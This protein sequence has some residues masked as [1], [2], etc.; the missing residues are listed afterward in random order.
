MSIVITIR[1]ALPMTTSILISKMPKGGSGSALDIRNS[2]P[3]TPLW[4]L[5]SST[6]SH[7]YRKAYKCVTSPSKPYP[8]L[9][10]NI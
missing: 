1:D 4:N 3:Y 9:E 2:R 6:I 10:I 8:S 7:G 5:C